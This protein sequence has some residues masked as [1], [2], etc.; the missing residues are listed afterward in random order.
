MVCT[1]CKNEIHG[2]SFVYTYPGQETLIVCTS[3]MKRFTNNM[4][5]RKF[6]DVFIEWLLV[7]EP[8][9][10]QFNISNDKPDSN[11]NTSTDQTPDP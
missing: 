6:I 9:I 4:K 7:N 5:M 1:K 8:L 2:L 3:C 10:T 11:G